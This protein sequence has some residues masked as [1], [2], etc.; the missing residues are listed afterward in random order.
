MCLRGGLDREIAA[1][2]NETSSRGAARARR[3]GECADRYRLP[4]AWRGS[5]PPP[6]KRSGGDIK[7]EEERE[8]IRQPHGAGRGGVG[9]KIPAPTPTTTAA[10]LGRRVGL[11]VFR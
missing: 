6:G 8:P 11:C 10:G 9:G 3:G 1:G 7:P 5:A 4:P 2:R